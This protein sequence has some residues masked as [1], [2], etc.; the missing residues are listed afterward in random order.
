[1]TARPG[2]S[3]RGVTVGGGPVST[4]PDPPWASYEEFA[5]WQESFK[6]EDPPL[7]PGGYRDNPKPVPTIE[8]TP[9]WWERALCAVG[10]HTG[11]AT[12]VCERCR[13]R[14]YPA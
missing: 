8:R 12:D 2:K 1:M 14:A 4:F 9:R 11:N 10:I 3:P 6:V 5:A 13:T 7:A